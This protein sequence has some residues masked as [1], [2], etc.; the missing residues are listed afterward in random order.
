MIIVA[1][2][3]TYPPPEEYGIEI[4]T[5]FDS[6][7]ETDNMDSNTEDEEQNEL[8]DNDFDDNAS[9]RSNFVKIKNKTLTHECF[10]SKQTEKIIK[11]KNLTHNLLSF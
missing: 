6:D 7:F 10:D 3:E 5:E 2:R 8:E 1:W 11:I 4:G 9:L